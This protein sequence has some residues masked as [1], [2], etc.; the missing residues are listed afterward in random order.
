MG[1]GRDLHYRMV[2]RANRDNLPESHPLRVRAAELLEIFQG[3]GLPPT[4]K[5]V[6]AWARARRAWCE[7]AG[8]PLL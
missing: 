8:E 1:K 4:P 5:I 3:P 6:G 2:E 7:Y